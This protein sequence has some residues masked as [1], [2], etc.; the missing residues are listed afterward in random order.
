[1]AAAPR[2][3]YVGC[4]RDALPVLLLRHAHDELIFVDIAPAPRLLRGILRTLRA[5]GV[6]YRR[7]PDRDFGCG[8]RA[9]VFQLGSRAAATSRL[10]LLAGTRD[11]DLLRPP[12]SDLVAS[13]T[14]LW[15]NGFIPWL[16][17]EDEIPSA[18]APDATIAALLPNLAKVFVQD[19][20]RVLR[21]LLPHLPPSLPIVRLPPVSF[22]P[23]TLFHG[24]NPFG[25]SFV[26]CRGWCGEGE[27]RGGSQSAGLAAE[28][29]AQRAP[30]AARGEAISYSRFD[31]DSH[32][33]AG[34]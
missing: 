12:L 2:L 20:P 14:S 33:A 6:S 3:L 11:A 10:I 22:A 24:E 25:D 4:G 26:V 23:H 13:T 16:G 9:L 32:P 29:R 34:E 28:G 19:S 1:M 30:E 31:L 15:V 8:F 5:R 17:D 7:L 21:A 27:G 18:A